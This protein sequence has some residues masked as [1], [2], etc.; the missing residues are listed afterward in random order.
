MQ[1]LLLLASALKLLY[2][3]YRDSDEVRGILES[4]STSPF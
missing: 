3:G 1:I 4:L 2:G